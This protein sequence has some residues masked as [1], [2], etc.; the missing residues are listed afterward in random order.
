MIKPPRFPYSSRIR[1]LQETLNAKGIDKALIL[2][3]ENTYYLSLF[4]AIIY[5]RPIAVIVPKEGD[6]ELIVPYLDLEHAKERSPIP[7]IEH[8]YREEEFHRILKE[9]LGGVRRLGLDVDSMSTYLKVKELSG[10]SEVLSISEDIERMRMIKDEAEVWRI[11]LAASITDH[12]MKEVMEALRERQSEV[13]AATRGEYAMKMRLADL[14]GEEG[15]YPWMNWTVAAALSGPRSFYPH[16]MVS[17]RKV[18]DGDVVIV[19]LDIAVEGYRAENERTFVVGRPS[20]DVE[21]Y[22]NI[23]EEAQ[24]RAIESLSP[25]RLTDEADKNA[26]EVFKASDTIKYVKHRTGHGIGLEIHEKPYLAEGDGTL[27][28]EGMVLCVEPGI[29]V[30]E[31]GGF[32]HSDTVLVTSGGH[33]V[34]T[35]TYKGL[36]ALSL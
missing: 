21:R 4:Q 19:T 28:R 10:G 16:G 26:R 29:Y 2:K 27:L 1:K 9:E 18:R 33:E 34:L 36:V 6:P 13:V 30:P 8:Y 25:G 24:S 35:K 15:L 17:G 11:R 5:T 22:F 20:P 23:M 31:L 12:G 32:R 3:P 14:L 7:K